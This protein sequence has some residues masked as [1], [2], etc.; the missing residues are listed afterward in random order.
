MTLR[1]QL[2]EKAKELGVRIGFASAADYSAIKPLRAYLSFAKTLIS[3]AYPIT[4]KDGA[5]MASFALNE[6]YHQV[7]RRI[8]SELVSVLPEC[9]VQTYVDNGPVDDRLI[10]YLAGMGFQGNNTCIITPGHGSYQLLGD[11]VVDIEFE[12]NTPSKVS[13]GTC[14]RCIDACPVACLPGDVYE[15]C[16]VGLLQQK[17]VYTDEIY[18]CVDTIYGCDICQSVCP[19][20]AKVQTNTSYTYEDLDITTILTA[21][22]ESFQAFQDTAFY[23]LGRFVMQR[24]VVIYAANKGL[25]IDEYLNQLDST[26]D[27]LA[28]AI[29]YYQR[30][31]AYS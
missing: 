19:F 14:T 8:M 13:C 29:D 6:D 2:L 1:D 9:T 11:I 4:K 5:L 22:K 15:N 25:D 27:Y 18:A 20:N 16:L 10:A 7:L 26:K 3:V 21:T 24:N 23:W 17:K 31:R 28:A 30:K 12:A